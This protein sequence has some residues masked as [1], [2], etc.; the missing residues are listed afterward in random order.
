M[1]RQPHEQAGA[2]GTKREPLADVRNNLAAEKAVIPYTE[3]QKFFAKGM[4]VNVDQ[5]LDLI[6]VA[7]AMAMD[8]ATQ[9]QDWIKSGLVQRAHDEHARNWT[10]ADARLV[11][12][13]VTPWILVQDL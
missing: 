7:V 3:L 13:T 5:S 1:T 12:V 4:L 9:L 8:D 6:D 2:T 10:K 11:A